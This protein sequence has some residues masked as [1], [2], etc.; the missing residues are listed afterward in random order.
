[1]PPAAICLT[2]NTGQLHISHFKTQESNAGRPYDFSLKGDV[3]R[4]V[5]I[6]L[7]PGAPE[8]KRNWLISVGIRGPKHQDRVGLPLPAGSKISGAFRK[9]GL[10]YMSG[11]SGQLKPTSPGPLDIRHAQVVAR[12]ERYERKYPCLIETQLSENIAVFFNHGSDVSRGYLRK[13]FDSLDESFAT[14]KGVSPNVV[15]RTPPG[16]LRSSYPPH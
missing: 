14:K 4:T 7:A 10:V 13:I 8:A 12:Y 5:D 9:A 11:K 3:R 1:M 6:T 15:A 16:I 2:N